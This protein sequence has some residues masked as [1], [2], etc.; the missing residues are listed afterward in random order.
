VR[1]SDL[2]D[3]PERLAIELSPL[4]IDSDVLGL[5]IRD[6]PEL[7]KRTQLLWAQEKFGAL[8]LLALDWFGDKDHPQPKER[9]DWDGYGRTPDWERLPRL[10][11][12][13]PPA[14]AGGR[15]AAS[16]EEPP[17]MAA[18]GSDEWGPYDEEMLKKAVELCLQGA[19]HDTMRDEVRGLSKRQA[20]YIAYAVKA[21]EN[22]LRYTRY[23]W[24]GISR[25]GDDGVYIPRT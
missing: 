16:S 2:F 17:A 3:K 20:R 25:T 24:E 1:W 9:R 21:N 11:D 13:E 23:G 22:P 8:L 7:R 14:V 4:G 6:V 12:D 18:A 19:S 15:T 10:E 5:D